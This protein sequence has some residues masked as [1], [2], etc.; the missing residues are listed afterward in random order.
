M[1][2][3]F[4]FPPCGQRRGY[5]PPLTLRFH[6]AVPHS[7]SALWWPAMVALVTHGTDNTPLAIHRTYSARDGSGRAAVEQDKMMLGPT[8]GGAVRLSAA[9]E[10][11]MVVKA[12]RLVCPRAA[13][14]RQTHVGGALHLGG[15]PSTCPMQCA[16]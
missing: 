12:S 8:S 15:G 4:C 11:L 14:N 6:P 16:R 10:T 9:G 5:A 1:T 13:G 2:G 7:P 3:H